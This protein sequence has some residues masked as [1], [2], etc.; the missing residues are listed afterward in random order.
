MNINAKNLILFTGAGFTKNFG[1]LLGEEM[2]ALI[3]NHPLVQSNK[4]L[5][6]LLSSE[7]NYEWAYNIVLNAKNFNEEDRSII[8]KV[9]EE[10]YKKLDDTVKK[11]NYNS[12]NP[13]ALNIYGLKKL[14]TL[15][16]G[17][18]QEQGFVFTLNQDIF[19]ERQ[20]FSWN[21]LAM[22]R[23]LHTPIWD[24]ER[25]NFVKTPD[26]ENLDFIQDLSTYGNLLYVKLHGSYGWLSS[27][28]ENQ[29]VIGGEKLEYINKEPLLK[30]YFNIFKKV[31][32]QDNKKIVIIGYGF[33]DSHIN[34]IFVE[35][36]EKHNLK[37][38]IIN[39]S[40]PAQ[41][42]EKMQDKLRNKKFTIFWKALSGYFPHSLKDI[43][44]HDQHQH[45]TVLFNNIK[46]AI[47]L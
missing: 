5:K 18:G 11:W 22:P 28:G 13:D 31:I 14:I 41:F 43:F 2:W 15:F 19:M 39:P 36:A 38:Y 47:I 8:K 17:E 21:S 46:S 40:S 3:F 37:F 35:G 16:S 44:P 29:M 25:E 26:E 27:S 23:L 12:D 33:N 34:D 1:G 9:V 7:F 42:R 10:A 45:P 4:Q 20:H 32:E 30:W 6:D 24:F